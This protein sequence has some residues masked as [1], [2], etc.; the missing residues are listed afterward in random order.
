MTPTLDSRALNLG[1]DER[2]TPSHALRQTT[3][4]NHLLKAFYGNPSERREV[5]VLADEVGMGKTYV[6]LATAYTLLSVLRDRSKRNGLSDLADCYKCVLVITPGGNSTLADKWNLEDE[7]LLTRCAVDTQQSEWFRSI[8]CES[9]D[10]LLQAVYKANDLRRRGEPVIVIAQS[11]IFTK[12]LSDSAIRFFTA[13]LFR[14]WGNGLQ[15]RE[16][17]HLVR[18]LSQT[19]GSSGWEDAAQWASRGEYEIAL[20]DW[21][22][23]EHYLQ[24][25]DKEQA[26]WD[27]RWERRLFSDVSITY[28]QMAVALKRFTDDGGQALLDQL[29]QLCK[30][31]PL[32]QPADRR[33]V[34]YSEWSKWFRLLKSELRN[35]FRQLWKYLLDRPFPLVITDEAHHWRNNDAGDFR[36]IREFIAPYARRMLLL[37]A[38]PFQLRPQ[39]AISILN[40]IE[41]MEKAIGKDR[42]AALRT[43]R[44]RMGNCME[45]SEHAGRAFSIEW[46]AVADQIGRWREDLSPVALVSRRDYDPRTEA[47]NKI[48]STLRVS[49]PREAATTIDLVPGPIRPFFLRAL[50]LYRANQQLRAAMTPLVVRHRRSTSHRRYWVGR[51]YPAAADQPL[52][53]DYSRLHLAPGQELEPKE[54]LVQY[55]LMNVVAALSRG[56]HRTTLGTALT[57]CYSTMWQSKEGRAAI[58]SAAKSDHL[59]L[60]SLLQRLTG[61]A[62]RAKDNDHPK[63]RRVVN[64]VLERWDRGEK[65]LIFCFRVPTAEALYSTLSKQI[66]ERLEGKRR[67]LLKARGTEIERD[68]DRDKAMQQFRRSLTAREA[69]GVPLFVDRVLAGWLQHLGLQMP[70]L[71]PDDIS[72]IADLAARASFNDRPLFLDLERP[73]RVFLA[74]AIEHVIARRMEAD[75]NKLTLAGDNS[76]LTRELLSEIA[77]ETWVRDRY[78]QVNLSFGHVWHGLEA[79]EG[80]ARSTLAARYELAATATAERKAALESDL[81]SRFQSTRNSVL[82]SLTEGPNL[83][84]PSEST[85]VDLPV[86]GRGDAQALRKAMLKATVHEGVWDWSARRDAVDALMRALLRDDLLL[87]MPASVFRGQDETWAASL[88]A[89]LHKPF[90]AREANETLAQRVVAFLQE[91]GR[92]RPKERESYLEYAMNPRAE[93]VALVKGETKARSAVF[94]GFNTPLLPE[95]LV[96]TA[97]GQE[98]ID[99]HRECSHVV[100][101]DL[102]WNPATIEQRTGRVDRIGS[103]VERERKLVADGGSGAWEH[104]MPGLEVALPYLA[105]TYDERMF[106]VLRTRAQVFEILTGGDPTADRPD[107]DAWA[108]T[109]QEGTD[110]GLA[111]VPLPQQMLDDLKVDL[112]VAPPV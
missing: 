20:W 86:R 83:F 34:E 96:C 80:A 54:E 22:R 32:R 50:E 78:G 105:A 70:P 62:E 81:L 101:Y 108:T 25:T 87:R 30:T 75:L 103:K 88:F 13:C 31:V 55:L 46:G 69:S 45:G 51:E 7:A 98:G 8:L 37:T 61:K 5:Q 53:P 43:L 99:L 93:S 6:A 73:D 38:T 57:G 72:A 29:R 94:A 47:I 19:A 33:T 42:V 12:K 66:A 10:Q 39:E 100:H 11:N 48:W 76:R 89:G 27:P 110:P 35:I 64:T 15:M 92:M 4:V 36:A 1:K 24:M 2:V 91:L 65:S 60:L 107:E 16:R 68:E 85:L 109:D 84:A 63:L 14:W 52:R 106:D 41:P 104:D 102:G 67:A 28:G 23:H 95:I 26:Q 77:Q 49:M 111:F 112:G 97:V 3:T 18:G 59:G 74:R 17:Y 9:A 82:H 44:E 40:V 71:I 58:E 56:R 79:T 90:G 21:S